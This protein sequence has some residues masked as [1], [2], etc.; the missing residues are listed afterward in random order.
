M[1]LENLKLNITLKGNNDNQVNVNLELGSWELDKE[2]HRDEC[3][4]FMRMLPVLNS[5]LGN[6]SSDMTKNK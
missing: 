3:E 4:L 6:L 5:M 1:K 2:E